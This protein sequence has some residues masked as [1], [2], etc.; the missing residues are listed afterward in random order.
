MTKRKTR[1]KKKTTPKKKTTT[2]KNST[3]KKSSRLPTFVFELSKT[4]QKIVE[5]SVRR[6]LKNQGYSGDTLNLYVEDALDSKVRDL[7]DDV[8]KKLK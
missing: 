7:P 4:K 5:R 3:S 2:K 1:T 6:D 8:V